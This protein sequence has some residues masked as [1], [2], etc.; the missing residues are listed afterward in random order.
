[1]PK[2]EASKT[3]RLKK[4]QKALLPPRIDCKTVPDTTKLFFEKT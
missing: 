3:K 4:S 1:M 2:I